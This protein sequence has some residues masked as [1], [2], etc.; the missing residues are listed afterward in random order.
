MADCK[1]PYDVPE[2][3]R[4]VPVWTGP[5]IRLI[6]YFATTVFDN[7]NIRLQLSLNERRL[8]EGSHLFFSRNIMKL[9][10]CLLSQDKKQEI[11]EIC[12]T[13]HTSFFPFGLA[14]S[15]SGHT[16]DTSWSSYS[17]GWKKDCCVTNGDE[18][19]PP[20][21]AYYIGFSKGSLTH[22]GSCWS[23]KMNH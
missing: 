2:L 3:G 18:S 8:L 19:P 17:S 16:G 1:I 11:K 20:P 10:V 9:L 7:D 6:S 15:Y 14:I 4:N 22:T 21:A 12:R 23:R 13:L 5:S